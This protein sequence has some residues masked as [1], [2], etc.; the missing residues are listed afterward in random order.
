MFSCF[1]EGMHDASFPW[2]QISYL[3]FCWGIYEKLCLHLNINIKRCFLFIPIGLVL[4][5]MISCWQLEDKKEILWL[6][7]VHPSSSVLEDL[8]YKTIG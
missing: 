4:L 5:L 7:P 6:N 3:R 8:R 2:G 1:E